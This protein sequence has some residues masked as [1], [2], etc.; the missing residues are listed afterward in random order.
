MDGGE[1]NVAGGGR[2]TKFGKKSLGIF[3]S[4]IHL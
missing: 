3:L 2:R 1:S 4:K